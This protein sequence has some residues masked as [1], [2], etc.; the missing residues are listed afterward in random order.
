MR[1]ILVTAITASFVTL[2]F[3]YTARFLSEGSEHYVRPSEIQNLEAKVSASLDS[4]AALHRGLRDIRQQL[5]LRN[6]VKD[7]SSISAIE[8]SE[9]MDI[10]ERLETL[11]D[12]LAALSIPQSISREQ[13]KDAFEQRI[14]ERVTPSVVSSTLLY[15][16]A[17]NYFER[18]SGKPLGD[19]SD[20]I[21]DALHAVEGI[22]LKG[23]DCR[24]TICKI[25]Y[26]NSEFATSAEHHNVGSELEDKLMFGTEGR[27]V[28]LRYANDSMGN[29]V[30]YAQVK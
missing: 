16:D 24:D 5:N 9:S 12:A 17:E 21:S 13:R 28:E 14:E 18:D 23:L 20:S 22:D 19:Y 27:A 15:N 30:I 11:E 6:G 10:S 4:I 3:V 7:S 1:L 26:S 8:D 29:N 2:L 25:T